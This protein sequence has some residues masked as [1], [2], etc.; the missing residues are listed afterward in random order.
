MTV[1]KPGAKGGEFEERLRAYFDHSGFLAVR[2]V[3]F[4]FEKE[5][6]SDV[7]VWLYERPN[8]ISRRRTILDAKNKH[9]PKAVERILWIK[10]FQAGLKVEGAIVATTDR[11]PS[12]R[13][14]ASSLGVSV[15]DGEALDRLISTQKLDTEN[16]LTYEDF[17]NIV[18]Y[19]DKVR[20]D[21]IWRDKLDSGKTGLLTGFGFLSANQNLENARFFAEAASSSTRSIREAASRAFFVSACYAAASLDFA[22]KDWGFRSVEERQEG[23]ILGLRFGETGA[24]S[25]L[26]AVQL[27]LGLVRHYSE[28]GTA[29]S[30]QIEERFLQDA[31]KIRVEIIAEYVSKIS[32][33]DTLFKVS[34]ELDKLAFA[35]KP[36]NYDSLTID[37]KSFLGVILDAFEVSRRVL[38]KMFAAK[39]DEIPFFAPDLKS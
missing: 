14:F 29:I 38:D 20:E 21:R 34:K 2:G 9:R 19:V 37:S 23:L 15:L 11:R 17:Y 4:V 7:D 27:A 8:A 13:R 28:N 31:A 10:G 18:S 6:V 33:K 22:V 30:R 3:P 25:T 32:N 36:Q 24:S 1:R 39:Q 26:D 16:R 5:D 12:V 35:S